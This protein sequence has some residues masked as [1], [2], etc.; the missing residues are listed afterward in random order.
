MQD[1]AALLVS[2]RGAARAPP[3]APSLH[4]GAA[5]AGPSHA[6]GNSN[7]RARSPGRL[8]LERRRRALQNPSAGAAA[9]GEDSAAAEV[10][11]ADEGGE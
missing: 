7:K 11:E 10:D 8:N 9:I 4:I 5:G 2:H 3:R 1:L 6:Q